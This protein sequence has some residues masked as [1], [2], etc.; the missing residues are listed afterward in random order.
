MLFTKDWL[1]DKCL[2]VE[3][4]SNSF[5]KERKLKK[6]RMAK[7]KRFGRM[8][9]LEAMIVYDA[10]DADELTSGEMTPVFSGMNSGFTDKHGIQVSGAVVSGMPATLLEE[11]GNRVRAVKAGEGLN[12][13]HATASEAMLEGGEEENIVSTSPLLRDR[14]MKKWKLR[15]ESAMTKEFT[16]VKE[17]ELG[18]GGWLAK[19][20]E[21]MQKVQ[22][23]RQED[24]KA[25]VKEE[26]WRK[27]DRLRQELQEAVEYF[28][29]CNLE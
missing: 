24:D 14:K 27:K 23:A 2:Q 13:L 20:D 10:L 25:T 18:F 16:I 11:T 15:T 5:K 22:L 17:S 3:E 29:Y 19:K 12:S 26:M 4:A 8:P 7:R 9:Q 6:V 1:E 28:Q 21:E